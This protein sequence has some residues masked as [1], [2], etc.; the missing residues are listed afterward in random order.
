MELIATSPEAE[1]STAGDPLCPSVGS[2]QSPPGST[3][4]PKAG[5]D[6]LSHR[7]RAPSAPT[8]GWDS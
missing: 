3:H 5:T 2:P 8:P 7:P 4:H 6:P 1:P